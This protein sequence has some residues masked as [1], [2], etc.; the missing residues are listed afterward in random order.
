M[1]TSP[2]SFHLETKDPVGR[3]RRHRL[4]ILC[5]FA[6]LSVFAAGTASA[7]SR[8]PVESL[9]E[10]R[11]MHVVRQE[12]DLSCGAAA[13]ATILRYQHG[14]A[15]GEREVA[16]GLIARKEYLERPELVRIR[17]GFSLLDLRRYVETLGYEGLGYGKLTLPDLIDRAPAIVPIDPG[18]YNHFVVFRGVMRN[19][20]LLADPAYGN[21]TMTFDQFTEA[22]ID[23]PEIGRV[24]FIVRR[25]DGLVPPNRLTPDP[26][27]FLTFR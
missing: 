11:T 13:L 20:V 2:W 26:A 17:Q 9:F 19:R 16:L 14:E 7:E 15:I 8:R 22:W 6:I 18:G 12:F 24:G 23:F 21:R 27:E 5:L 10:R 3:F 4:L 25:R 1:N